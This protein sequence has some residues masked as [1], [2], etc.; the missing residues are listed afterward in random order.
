MKTSRLHGL[1]RM[2]L[3]ARR[4]VVA[5]Q[6][7]L[8]AEAMRRAADTG[9]LG[10]EAAQHMVENALGVFGMPWGVA[11]NLRV[12]GVD[13]LVPMVVEEPSVIAAVSQ[14]ALWVRGS[15]N[16][17]G[18]R[19]EAMP[20]HTVAQLLFDHVPERERAVCAVEQAASELMRLADAA[21][22]NL[23]RRGGGARS[24]RVR[25]LGAPCADGLAVDITLDCVD[26]MGANLANTV[27]EALR[28]RCAK[29]VGCS[30]NLAILSNLADQR[31]VRARVRVPVCTWDSADMPGQVVAGRIVAAGR[32]AEA[33]VYRAV[34]HNKGILNG[35]GALAVATG[36]D[37]RAIEAGAH[38]YASLSG[39]YRPLATWAVEGEDLVGA[40]CMPMALGAVGGVAAVHEGVRLN[41][42]MLGAPTAMRLASVAAAV[43]LCS[44]LAA[45]VALSTVGI[46][47]GHMRLHAR[48]SEIPPG[49]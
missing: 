18:I 9:G 22:P 10:A 21:V 34:T 32:L 5:A 45:L 1:H 17:Q 47:A 27:A 11:T 23:C 16:A 44:N 4:A 3:D 2:D 48:K 46:Q 40:L 41:L 25:R 39:M 31:L 14:A 30:A 8:D 19:T 7:N 20:A 35:V 42:A 36:N 13:A 29:L 28:D 38:G 6:A 49:L 33:D 15:D 26:A 24:V 37:W 43:G 12:D